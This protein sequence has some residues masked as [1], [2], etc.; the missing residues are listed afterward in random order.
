MMRIVL[1]TNLIISGMLWM[2]LPHDMLVLAYQHQI[3]V[4]ASEPLIEEL[5]DVLSREKMKK[6]LNRIQKTPDE[7][8]N[9]H[10]SHTLIIEPSQVPEGTVRDLKDD[11]IIAC[12]VGGQA[13]YI[14]T[15]DN[16]LLVLKEYQG[17]LIV[18]ASEFL[19][20]ITK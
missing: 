17:I 9:L 1:D 19:T 11:K 3:Q 10:L 12:A 8:I 5:K 4:I 16:D 13:D 14:I 7:L 6:H 2:G 15:G 18:T 20:I